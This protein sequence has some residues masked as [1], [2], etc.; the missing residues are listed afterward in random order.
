MSRVTDQPDPILEDKSLLPLELFFDLVFVLGITQTV[1]LVVPGHDGRALWRAGLV[2]AML[3]WAWT[4]FAWT[5]NSIDLRPARTRL[6][7]FVAMGAALTMA[8]S[9]VMV[10]SGMVRPRS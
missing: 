7:F 4:Q 6:A 10:N 5:A 1:S 9:R 8:V 3:W 2:L